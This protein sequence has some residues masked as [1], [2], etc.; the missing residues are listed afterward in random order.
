MGEGTG[1]LNLFPSEMRQGDVWG[2]EGAIVDMRQNPTEL[3]WTVWLC[4]HDP[5]CQ[6]TFKDFVERR[7]PDRAPRRVLRS[8]VA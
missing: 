3:T 5:V 1:W 4:A 8:E 7:W 6:S 2:E